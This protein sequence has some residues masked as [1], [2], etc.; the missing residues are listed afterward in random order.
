MVRVHTKQKTDAAGRFIGIDPLS[1][2]W[3]CFIF[4]CRLVV[5]LLLRKYES[6]L[7]WNDIPNCTEI[8]QTHVPTNKFVDFH[9][10]HSSF[11]P[12]PQCSG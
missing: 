2:S 5:Y 4:F 12:S 11:P 3:S 8:R 6:Q 7:G 9:A 10:L 1:Y